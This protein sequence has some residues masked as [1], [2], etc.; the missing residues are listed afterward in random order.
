LSQHREQ[1]ASW[2]RPPVQADLA[3]VAVVVLSGD[4]AVRA[5]SAGAERLHGWRADEATGRDYADLVAPQETRVIIR[6]LILQSVDSGRTPGAFEM[7]FCHRDGQ[8]QTAWTDWSVLAG[9]DGPVL[10]IVAV[11]LTEWK[12]KQDQE[13]TALRRRY[14]A[15]KMAMI[16]DLVA[17]VSHH[18]NN[19]LMVIQGSAEVLRQQARNEP[20]QVELADQILQTARQL[21]QVTSQLMAYGGETRQEPAPV[22]VHEL[23]RSAVRTLAIDLDPS[24]ELRTDLQAPQC[25]VMAQEGPLRAALRSLGLNACEAIE[26]GGRV[27]FATDA[28]ELDPETCEAYP[29]AIEPGPFLRIAVRDTG[30]G[31]DGQTLQRAFDPFFTRKPFGQGSDGLGLA[32][33]YGSI[34]VHGGAVHVSSAPGAGTEV[35]V[36]L[37]LSSSEAVAPTASG[38]NGEVL[39]AEAD[40]ASRQAL[41]DI[42]NA[43]GFTARVFATGADAV[44]YAESHASGLV[45]AVVDMT[46]GEAAGAQ[47]LA[48]LRAVDRGLPI[49]VSGGVL[50]AEQAQAVMESGAA[51]FLGKPYN[52]EQVIERIEHVRNGR[53]AKA[54]P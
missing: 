23:I 31:M 18:V 36:F 22:D 5:W 20:E 12:A 51:G 43:A 15:Q 14:G 38:G 4:G 39:A 35:E 34:K 53:G 26:D 40:P 24:I 37:P 54:S 45:A 7:R 8:E 1:P 30:V 33:I 28:V 9:P 25:V 42:V 21:A 11:D 16:S 10:T 50:S 32:E 52:R 13:T 44:T 6:Q 17:G 48:A 41:A 2:N 27:T 47:T 3:S 49:L 19:A 46:A 29:Y